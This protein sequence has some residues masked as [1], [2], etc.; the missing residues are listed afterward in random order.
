MFM[1]LFCGQ[2]LWQMLI[3]KCDFPFRPSTRPRGLTRDGFFIKKATHRAGCVVVKGD[4][5]AGMGQVHLV[6]GTLIIRSRIV[7]SES[8]K[9]LT[10]DVKPSS[11]RCWSAASGTPS[12]LASCGTSGNLPLLNLTPIRNSTTLVTL[13]GRAAGG[14]PPGFCGGFAFGAFSAMMKSPCV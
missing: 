4:G 14:C 8:R 11:R 12:S 6:I 7:G 10:E 13:I 2:V 5:V 1:W 9:I 3:V